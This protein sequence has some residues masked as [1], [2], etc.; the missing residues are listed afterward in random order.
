MEC[1]QVLSAG[2]M[3]KIQKDLSNF[4]SIKWRFC[5]IAQ[6]KNRLKPLTHNREPQKFS[7]L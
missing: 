4:Q 1:T 5:Q 3:M 7:I 6:S 2:N